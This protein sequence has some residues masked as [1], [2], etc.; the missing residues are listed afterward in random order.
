MTAM[1]ISFTSH[2]D[3]H[4]PSFDSSIG[5]PIYLVQ[6]KHTNVVSVVREFHIRAALAIR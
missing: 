4:F 1:Q 6:Y 5:F 2:F 3:F